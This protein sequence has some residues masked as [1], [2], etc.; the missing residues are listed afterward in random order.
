[1]RPSKDCTRS[2]QYRRR[3]QRTIWRATRAQTSSTEQQIQRA[4]LSIHDMASSEAQRKRTKRTWRKSLSL[5]S[6]KYLGSASDDVMLE[7]TEAG[8]KGREEDD[9]AAVFLLRFCIARSLVCKYQQD[10][11]LQMQSCTRLHLHLAGQNQTLPLSLALLPSCWLFDIPCA[12]LGAWL[13]LRKSDK[14]H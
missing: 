12:S 5:Y 7:W 11:A 9:S 10:S 2:G 3:Q 4:N 8:A 14:R 13:W 6:K 1:M